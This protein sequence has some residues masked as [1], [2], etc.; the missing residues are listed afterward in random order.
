MPKTKNGAQSATLPQLQIEWDEV[1]DA[2]TY[3][4][5]RATF[6]HVMG[7]FEEVYR[8]SATRSMQPLP[9][10]QTNEQ[11]I[12]RVEAHR[13]HLSERCCASVI[14]S[15]AL[16][17]PWPTLKRSA[18]AAPP[19]LVISGEDT[20][21]TTSN[22]DNINPFVR[23][24]NTFNSTSIDSDDSSSA[25]SHA[26]MV[27]IVAPVVAMGACI[28][29]AMVCMGWRWHKQR[30]RHLFAKELAARVAVSEMNALHA[31]AKSGNASSLGGTRSPPTVIIEMCSKPPIPVLPG[32]FK[33]TRQG[34]TPF[35]TPEHSGAGT[36]GGGSASTTHHRAEFDGPRTGRY[37][38]T[39]DGR[40]ASFAEQAMQ[41]NPLVD[42][43]FAF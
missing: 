32:S 26:V 43:R 22:M 34:Q 27:W 1:Q 17:V 13:A 6:V 8:G 31:S 4:L 41:D 2:H 42:S 18:W 25:G 30:R 9:P 19:P 20:S 36:G 10:A 38:V 15:E 33:L 14:R 24:D 40:T 12:Y 35:Q 28:I 21:S 29:V 3:V 5:Q 11:H 39:G 37:S 23:D 16:L 7:E